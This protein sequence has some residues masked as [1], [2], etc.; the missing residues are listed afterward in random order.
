[1]GNGTRTLRPNLSAIAF[2]NSSFFSRDPDPASKTSQLGIGTNVGGGGH[3]W[4]A[5][6]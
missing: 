1:M 3:S 2:A 6:G 4:L 5:A